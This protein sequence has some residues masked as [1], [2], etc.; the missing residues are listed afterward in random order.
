MLDKSFIFTQP[1]LDALTCSP[2][3]PLEFEKQVI[4]VGSFTTHLPDGSVHQ[5][6]EVDESDIDN[7]VQQFSQMSADGVEVPMPVR[8][9]TDPTQ[10]A[11]K[12]TKLIKKPDSKGRMSLYVSGEFISLDRA[13]ELKASQVSLHSP[14]AIAVN[15]KSYQRPITHIAF[16]DYPSIPDLEQLKALSLSYDKPK[17][18]DLMTIKQYAEKLGITVADDMS[19]EE[20]EKAIEAHFKKPAQPPTEPSQETKSLS[21]DQQALLSMVKENRSMKIDQ[22]AKEGRITPA[23]AKSFKK[24]FVEAL[25]LDRQST[26]GFEATASALKEMPAVVSLGERSGSQKTS[27]GGGDS[28]LVRAAKLAAGKK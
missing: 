2:T 7:W 28:P 6:F 27:S 25:S 10:K 8:H 11:A 5:K 9:T 18:L 15:G 4:Y 3:S 23:V 19:D 1:D 22:L 24:E 21:N 17:E 26:D 16:T 20:I 12:A 13:K 14:K